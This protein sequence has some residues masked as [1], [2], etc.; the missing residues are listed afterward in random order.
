[1]FIFLRIIGILF[2]PLVWLYTL[3]IYLRNKFYDWG[4][5][6]S[7]SV[8]APV[9]SVGNIQL[10]GTGKT[11]LVEYI[12]RMLME[13]GKSVA[14]LSRGYRRKGKAGIIVEDDPKLEIT[15]DM[16]GDEPYLLKQNLPGVILGVDAS[17]LRMA[18]KILKRRRDVIFVLDDGFQHRRLRRDLDIVLIDVSR[19]SALPFL[20]PITYFRDVKYSLKRASCFVLNEQSEDKHKNTKLKEFLLDKYN[21][22]IF[23]SSIITQYLVSL[24]DEIVIK[25]EDFPDKNIFAFAGI[26]TPVNFFMTLKNLGFNILGK[27]NFQDHHQYNLKDLELIEKSAKNCNAATC[28]TTQKDAVKIKGLLKNQKYT[29]PIRFYYLRTEV[30]ILEKTEFFN[31]LKTISD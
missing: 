10:G 30:I 5:F 16:I 4:W 24:V 21:R 18:R 25:I 27:K 31:L 3:I 15:P 14:I 23:H 26:G 28:I 8:D 17:R 29:P 6:K 11:P 19:W 12:S 13:N 22:P 9:I 20:F 2:F 7:Y 1:M